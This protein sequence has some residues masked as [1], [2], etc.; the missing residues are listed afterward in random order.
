M[1]QQKE[2]KA[3]LRENLKS[4]PLPK[5]DYEFVLNDPEDD[6]SDVTLNGD[7]QING[8]HQND[9]VEDQSE[10]D[11]RMKQLQ[12]EKQKHEFSL[13]SQVIQR[14]LPRPFEVNFSILR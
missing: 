1:L 3:Q 4:L 2:Q 8:N 6:R 10:L 5:N 12:I 11:D 7:N 9:F 14:D 13:R